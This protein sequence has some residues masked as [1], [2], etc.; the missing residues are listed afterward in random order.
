MKKNNRYGLWIIMLCLLLTAPSAF[1]S[2]RSELLNLTGGKR[3]KIAWQEGRAIRGYDTQDSTRRPIDSG[4]VPM[5]THD[6]ARVVYLAIGGQSCRIVN[7]DGSGRLTIR[8]SPGCYP[9]DLWYNEAT[10]KEYVI[11]GVDWDKG[12]VDMVNI[13][14]TT[15]IIRL[16]TSPDVILMYLAMSKDGTRIGSDFPWPTP[17]IA[18]VPNGA[19]RLFT[20][21]AQ[22]CLNHL[23][24]DNTYRMMVFT[25]DHRYWWLYDQNENRLS[26]IK[27]NSAPG[28]RGWEAYNPR[29][30]NNPRFCTIDGPYDGGNTGTC[31]ADNSTCGL[32]QGQRGAQLNVYFGRFDS[33]YTRVEGW[34]NVTADAIENRVARSWVDDGPSQ[35]EKTE[36]ETAPFGLARNSPNPFNPATTISYQLANGAPVKLEVYDTRGKLVKT[37]AQGFQTAGSYSFTWDARNQPSGVYVYKL[38]AGTR[39]E[40][41]KGLLLK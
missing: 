38:T 25:P 1:G 37:L 11:V 15:E 6:G 36:A 41:K 40:T 30:T 8:T 10:Q 13:D 2:V 31:V 14:N 23:F 17:G 9:A 20:S 16:W 35:T 21:I 29:L 28:M 27:M 33:T 19:L 32:H 5:I 4:A 3:V 26:T 18:T 34:V 7:W 24:P 12:P 39:V 22:G